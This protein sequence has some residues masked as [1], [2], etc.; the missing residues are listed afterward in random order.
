RQLERIQ[1]IAEKELQRERVLLGRNAA[2]QTEVEDTTYRLIKARQL[3]AH[4]KGQKD[5]S[6]QYIRDLAALTESALARLR[7]LEMRSATS[8]EEIEWAQFR[9]L[10]AQQRLASAEGKSSRAR[11]VQVQ[12]EGL[13]AQMFRHALRSSHGTEEETEYLKWQVAFQRY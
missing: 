1:E 10:L 6:T 12:L 13:T 7:K 2:T 4:L 3:K 5:E 8:K 9:D 11:E